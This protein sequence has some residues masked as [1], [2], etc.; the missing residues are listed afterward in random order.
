M[1]ISGE[2]VRLEDSERHHPGE[3]GHLLLHGQPGT[4]AQVYD[5]WTGHAAL[6]RFFGGGGQS[7]DTLLT[8]PTSDFTEHCS[9]ERL[10]AESGSV[11]KLCGLGKGVHLA[12]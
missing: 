7:G 6:L 2:S 4:L 5:C 12:T 8:T 1:G 10:W 9:P 3:G 11:T